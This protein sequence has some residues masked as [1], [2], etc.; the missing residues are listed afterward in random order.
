[1][2]RGRRDC[3]NFGTLKLFIVGEEK[4]EDERIKKKKKIEED[5][6]S[7][8]TWERQGLNVRILLSVCILILSSFKMNIW[9]ILQA[10]YVIFNCF[11]RVWKGG[12]SF[13]LLS[14]ILPLF[15]INIIALGFGNSNL[16]N[17]TCFFSQLIIAQQKFLTVLLNHNDFNDSF[18]I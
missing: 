12:Y 3:I 17:R 1:M 15:S 2:T 9:F 13:Q 6:Q 10:F 18:S 5:A 4:K 11:F 14:P 16:H 8:F 7:C